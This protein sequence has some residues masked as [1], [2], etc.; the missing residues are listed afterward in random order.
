MVLLSPVFIFLNKTKHPN[1]APE[2]AIKLSLIQTP[3]TLVFDNGER[4]W[5][6][7]GAQAPPEAGVQLLGSLEPSS[8]DSP[9]GTQELGQKK[10]TSDLMTQFN[11]SYRGQY[12]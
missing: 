5:A 12:R 9:P 6:S 1:H 4:E 8:V 11:T 7:M 2:Y 10:T 3:G